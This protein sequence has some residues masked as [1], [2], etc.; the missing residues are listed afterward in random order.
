MT[1]FHTLICD[2][3]APQQARAW[4][5]GQLAVAPAAATIPAALADDVLLCV[6]ELVTNAVQACCDEAT[7]DLA[8]S[9]GRVRVV[10]TDNGHGWPTP[11]SPAPSDP[12]GRGLMII[13]AIADRWGVEPTHA[14]KTVW[15]ELAV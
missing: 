2:P 1:S 15:A 7:V 14:S 11:Q 13:A 5:Q 12:S 3:T 6:S 4:A 9:S 8:I 10:V